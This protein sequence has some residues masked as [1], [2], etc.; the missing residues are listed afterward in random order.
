MKINKTIY[1]ALAVL[2]ACLGINARAQNSL[3]TIEHEKVHV[4]YTY[5]D[6]PIKVMGTAKFDSLAIEGGV[7]GSVTK[8]EGASSYVVRV[9]SPGT[10]KLN[11]YSKGK[12]IDSREYRVKV[13]PSPRTI[14]GNHSDGDTLTLEEISQ[15]KSVSC[16]SADF[17]FDGKM[18]VTSFVI[19]KSTERS[20]LSVEIK[21]ESIS[22]ETRAWLL[23][24]KPG[25]K[26]VFRDLR[27]NVLDRI[28]PLQSVHFIVK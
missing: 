15:L 24:S 9:S 25:T 26:I 6:N 10:A 21:G 1:A 2:F 5:I 8:G 7:K 28:V 20:L 11:V 12:I 4:L 27:A 18:E 3:F 19:E 16:M 23:D 22:N 17:V 14:I 13:L